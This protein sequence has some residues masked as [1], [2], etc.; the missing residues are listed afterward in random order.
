MVKSAVVD[1]GL[2][3]VGRRCAGAATAR[4]AG[5][6]LV[7]AE[8]LGDVVVGA[9]RRAPR[10]C[11]AS[12]SR[13]DSTMIGHRASSP[14]SPSTTSMP[15]M[16]GR[17]R[18]R[19]TTSGWSRGG[20]RAAPSSPVGGEVDLVAARP[21][22]DGQRPADLRLVVDDQDAASSVGRQRQAR[23]PSVSAAARG[24]LDGELAAHGLD[25]AAGHREP[26]A[27]AGAVGA[28]A[29]ALERLEHPLAVV[30]GMPGPVVDDAQVDPV[31]D[32]A[33]LDAR[34]ASPGGASASALATRLASARSSRAGSAST[35]RQRL[36]HVDVDACP[37]SA[38][39]RRARAADDLVEADRPALHG[40]ARRSG[41]GSCR[42]GCRRGGSSRSVSSSMVSRNS[43]V[44][45]RSNGDV[46]LTAGS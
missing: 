32:R 2:R 46:A 14:R 1:D 17:P 11:R 9:R 7:H 15:S 24:V 18:S 38:Q 29:E 37:R 36:G 10:P 42:A 4:S 6:Q 5:Q 19:T 41:A 8:R 23:A 3:L 26:E 21:Q 35:A 40:A 30:G 16:P 43:R 31:A 34:P 45:R 33:G 22:V 13:T 28:V 12:A 44:A 39:R 27:D 25:E 20:Q